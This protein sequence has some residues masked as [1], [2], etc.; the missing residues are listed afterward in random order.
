MLPAY[1]T[2][3]ATPD[4]S[5]ICNLHHS[6]WQHQILSPLS[7]ARHQTCI[8]MD[9][10][11][12]YFYRATVGTPVLIFRATISCTKLQGLQRWGASPWGLVQCWSVSWILPTWKHYLTLQQPFTRIK[13]LGHLCPP[14]GWRWGTKAGRGLRKGGR[15]RGGGHVGWIGPREAEL[16]PG[17]H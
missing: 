5:H 16:A 15:Q 9:A 4:L 1:A 6:L 10:S 17:Y 8:L 12:I 13:T 3:I 11:Q 14:E 2:T 7:E